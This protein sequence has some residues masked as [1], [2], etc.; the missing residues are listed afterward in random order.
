MS[1]LETKLRAALEN[2]EKRLIRRRL[3]DPLPLP[4][5]SGSIATT[6]N[7]PSSTSTNDGVHL[8]PSSDL[9]PHLHPQNS[10]LNLKPNPPRTQHEVE[11]VKEDPRPLVDFTSND[12]LSLTSSPRLRDLF[13]QKLREAPDVLGSGGSRLL[14][15]GR[16]HAALEARLAAFFGGEDDDDAPLSLQQPPNPTLRSTTPSTQPPNPSQTPSQSTT[17]SYSENPTPTPKTKPNPPAQALLFNSGFDANAALFATL[18]QPGDALVYDAHI[19]ASVHD[20]MRA[21]RVAPSLR[22]AFAH[23]DVQDLR[24]VLVELRDG[25]GSSEKGN[26]KGKTP[27]ALG[28]SSIFVAIES[29]YSMDGTLSPLPTIAH[30]LT[31]LFPH[32]NAHLIID[33]AHSTGLYGPLGRGRTRQL[34][35]RAGEGCVLAVLHTFGKALGASGAVVVTGEAVREYLVNYARG[36]IYTTA[37]S[38]AGVVAAEA[39]FDLLEDGTAEKLSAH[40]FDL[41]TYLVTSLRPILHNIP[42]HILSLPAH[43]LLSP[44][45]SPSS[46]PSSS[47]PNPKLP[48]PNPKLPNPNPNP[49]NPDPTPPTHTPILPLLTSHP[50]PLSTHLAALGLNARP[51]TWPTVPKGAGRVRVCLHAG[52]GRADVDRL[53]E[54]VRGWVGGMVEREREREREGQGRERE[55]REGREGQEREGQGRVRREAEVRREAKL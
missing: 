34:G 23:N 51:I 1:A 13:M 4:S 42:P 41:S 29:L 27:F 7:P 28:T 20:G 24:R 11:Q 26:E 53:V 40:L 5:L 30:L 2:R 8:P 43:L 16:A 18:P 47:H 52:L 37:M 19:H 32:H 46:P 22:R 45:P 54:G 50:R 36:F 9:S 14:V 55:G 3:P 10:N 6:T 25:D 17:Q 15:N 48:N 49:P 44:S 21:S 31:S 35:L 33:E 38:C 39:S 12:Y